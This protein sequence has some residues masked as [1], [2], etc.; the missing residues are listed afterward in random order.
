MCTR[1]I[2]GVAAIL[3]FVIAIGAH[4]EELKRV[5]VDKYG[6]SLKIPTQFKVIG[7]IDKTTSWQFQPGSTP[8]VAEKKKKGGFGKLVKSAA[9]SVVPGADAADAAASASDS[10]TELEPA[11]QIYINWV[12]M[13]DVASSTM[14][15]TNKQADLKNIKSPDPDYKNLE[16]LDP[17]KGYDIEGGTAYRYKEVDKDEGS[18]IHRW[19]VKAFGNKS[20]YTMGFTGTF[21]QFEEWGPVFEKVIRSIKLI[22][23]KGKQ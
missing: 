20:M 11:V 2:A 12:W 1:L 6:Y 13:P 5:D 17:K 15:E 3:S 10:G 19:H 14:F 9:K 23:L 8:A 4:A 18:E 22:E 16:V 7:K 21:E